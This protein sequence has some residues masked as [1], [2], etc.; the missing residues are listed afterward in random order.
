MPVV[1]RCRAIL[2]S[3]CILT[4]N[5]C[6]K[7]SHD[8]YKLISSYAGQEIVKEPLP[9]LIPVNKS[10]TFS[11]KALCFGFQCSGFWVIDGVQPHGAVNEHGMRSHFYHSNDEYTLTLTVNASEAMNNTSIKCRYENLSGR[12]FHIIDSDT[13]YL[14]VISSKENL[15]LSVH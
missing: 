12:G 15:I 3:H 14:Y 11:C 1:I 9:L 13:V 7:I 8:F 6:I 2:S 10:G 4:Q 5:Q